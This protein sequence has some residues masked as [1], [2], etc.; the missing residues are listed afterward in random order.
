MKEEVKYF[1]DWQQRS[2]VTEKLEGPTGQGRVE[3]PNGDKFEGYFHLNFASIQGPCYVANGK[4][5]FADGKYIENAWINTSEDLT[6]F[7]LKGVYEV[8]N[9]DGSLA[10]ITSF[11]LN[12]RHGIEVV[13]AP[14]AEA[15]EWYLGKEQKRYE[16]DRYSLNAI[17]GNC[18]ELVVELA[19]GETITMVGGRYILNK[20]D[21]QVYENYLSGR[22]VYTNGEVYTSVNY[23]IRNLQPYDG[24]G[25]RSLL[26]G[27]IRDEYYKGYELTD[28]KDEHWD[29]ARA[30]V[31]NIPDPIHPE[32]FMEARVWSNHIEYGYNRNMIY[33]GDVVDGMPHGQGVLSNMRSQAF[34]NGSLSHTW[35]FTY[36]GTFEHGRCHGSIVFTDHEKNTTCEC[37]WKNGR[38]V[39]MAPVVLRYEWRRIL[40]GEFEIRTGT[41]EMGTGMKLPLD[42]FEYVY[43]LEASASQIAFNVRE[44]LRPGNSISLEK[45]LTYDL[46][47]YL[48]LY[49]DKE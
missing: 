15:V 36:K 40:E 27:K 11:W 6:K 14:S 8:H 9:A 45:E 23:N 21:N 30:E 12:E 33:D 10:S 49:W 4:Y 35:R 20:Y 39:G 41:V 7:G 19:T 42:G 22:I 1:G 16:I 25:T 5:T 47:Y 26:N 3:F 31:R 32:N 44:P 2:V 18:R 48:N 37:E 28:I 13:T 43:L 17:N 29:S 38:S 24:V 34:I 46:R